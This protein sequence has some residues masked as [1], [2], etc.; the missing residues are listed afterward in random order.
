MYIEVGN[1]VS[2]AYLKDQM[3]SFVFIDLLTITEDN[4]DFVTGVCRQAQHFWA[5]PEGGVL[6]RTGLLQYLHTEL[7]N[8][9]IYIQYSDK[10]KL[11][12]HPPAY[13]LNAKE[14]IPYDD[15]ERIAA[16]M[17]SKTRG[18]LNLA[19]G[20][21]KSFL[22]GEFF[23]Q[24]GRPNMLV[25]VPTVALLYQTSEDLEGMYG[26]SRGSVG[27]V[28]DGR[29]DWK[30]ITVA[31]TNSVC[32]KIDSIP[33]MFDAII[34]DEG[35]VQTG[36]M[37]QAVADSLDCFYRFWLSGTAQKE[38]TLHP[39]DYI[40]KITGMGGPVLADIRNKQLISWGRAKYPYIR[41]I[42]N[43]IETDEKIENTEYSHYKALKR[44]ESR[45]E[46]IKTVAED[47][48]ARGFTVLIFVAH[49]E[50][51][52]FLQDLLGRNVVKFVRGKNSKENDKIRKGMKEGKHKCVICSPTWRVGVSIPQVDVL[53]NAAGRKAKYQYLQV[54]GRLL[55]Q[56][57][58]GYGFFID[59]LDRGLRYPRRQAVRRLDAI[60]EEGLPVKIV[61]D[62]TR[63]FDT[64]A[65]HHEPYATLR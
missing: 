57:K 16:L 59:F 45:N 52:K 17:V 46:C 36:E 25:L 50:Q 3:E 41:F 20:Y 4:S 31:I 43:L 7:T 53:I 18:V 35:H 9:G 11:P 23:S 26:L 32:R 6:F 60:I 58:L 40:T 29:E 30:P 34:V 48:L 22:I 15:Q 24:A 61:K 42:D 21:G 55:R 54:F 39:K 10:R 65:E 12:R 56:S 62:I 38:D 44:N 5:R 19:T 13:P 64:K 28:G 8:R 51:G 33:D 27:K 1:I 49:V 14:F 2:V 37:A 47:A 63:V